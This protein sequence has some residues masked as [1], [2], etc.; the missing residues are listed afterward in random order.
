[1]GQV[2]TIPVRDMIRGQNSQ[3]TGQDSDIF[4]SDNS[5]LIDGD[6]GRIIDP[7]DGIA[8]RDLPRDS[9]LLMIPKTSW[10]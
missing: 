7:Q 1:M 4:K 8:M 5:V 2:K 6:T 3:F 10:H 9:N